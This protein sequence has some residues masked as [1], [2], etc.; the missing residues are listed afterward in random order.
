MLSLW[1]Q[2]HSL[3]R[4]LIR[5]AFVGFT[6]KRLPNML[7]DLTLNNQKRDSTHAQAFGKRPNCRVRRDAFTYKKD[8]NGSVARFSGIGGFFVHSFV[9]V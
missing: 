7:Q 1:D 4:S 5:L 8:R 3:H 2:I 9:Q 6:L